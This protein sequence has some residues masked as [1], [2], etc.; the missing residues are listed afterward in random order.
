[1]IAWLVAVG[2]GTVAH[3]PGVA[4]ADLSDADLDRELE[5]LHATRRETFLHGTADAL[6]AHTSRMLEL[7]E[8]FANR[9]PERVKT[10]PA[11][12]RAPG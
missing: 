11:R 2:E 1:V 5:R 6:K 9:F 8:E 7:E 4:P 10:D 12:Q 3:V